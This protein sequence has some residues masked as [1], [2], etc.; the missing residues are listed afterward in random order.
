MYRRFRLVFESCLAVATGVALAQTTTPVAFEVAVVR[1]APP[2]TELVKQLQSGKAPA[3]TTVDGYRYDAGFMSLE[4][5]VRTAF[6]VKPYQMQGPA[7]MR[8]QRFDIHATI[9]AGVSK[10]RVPEML[11]ALLADR[12]RMAVHT[13]KKDL[14]VYALIAGKNGT[15]LTPSAPVSEGAPEQGNVNGTTDQPQFKF[16]KNGQGGVVMQSGNMRTSTTAGPDGNHVEINRIT[17]AAFADVLSNYVDTPVIDMTGLTGEYQVALDLSPDDLRRPA[18]RAQ[19]MMAE[20]GLP[21]PAQARP[22]LSPGETSSP[23][24]GSVFSS[25]EKL[26]LKLEARKAP[27]DVLVIDHLEKTPTEN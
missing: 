22:E 18:Q 25:L 17:M 15:K 24:G 16:S 12:F 14:P 7:W 23:A 19:Q 4:D 21:L 11:Q 27:V 13:E 5:L 6:N 9:P 8:E 2:L 26:G 1:P 3:G 10:A 20:L